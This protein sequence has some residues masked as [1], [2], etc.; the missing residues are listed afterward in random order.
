MTKSP[1]ATKRVQASRSRR[2]NAAIRE[3]YISNHQRM[4]LDLDDGEFHLFSCLS[5][6]D[7]NLSE[8]AASGATTLKNAYPQICF[9]S[10]R[11]NV[12]Q[13]A[14]AMASNIVKNCQWINQTYKQSDERDSL[15]KWVD[16]NPDATTADQI[17]AGLQS[18]M[19]NWTDEQK[20]RLSKHF[21]GL[22]FDVQ[23]LSD[24][25]D[26][27][28]NFIK[29]LPHCMQFLDSEGGL[30]IWHAAFDANVS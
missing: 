2:S 15:Q 11:R 12:Q 25:A 19:Q 10:G 3:S 13:Q 1:K 6:D 22:A 24:N 7:L 16:D 27:V 17:S 23:P 5:V 26:E 28:K 29:T 20:G 21:A 4:L 30:V 9:T 14:D 8:Y 18:I